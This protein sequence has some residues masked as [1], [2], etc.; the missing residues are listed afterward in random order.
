MS[1]KS[2]KLWRKPTG[3]CRKMQD[4]QELRNDFHWARKSKQ[5]ACKTLRVWTK[6]RKFWKFSRKIWDFLSKS[7]WQ[8]DF[9]HNFLLNISWISAFTLNEP[10]EDNTRFL[11]QVF[12]F[13]G[14]G[15][16]WRSF[17]LPTLF[18]CLWFLSWLINLL[19]VALN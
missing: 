17:I 19:Q 11:Q 18:Y 12:R 2:S 4:Y 10:L 5:G 16:F 15:R 13:R 14:G 9:F 6:R 3:I 8:I 7:L 1:W